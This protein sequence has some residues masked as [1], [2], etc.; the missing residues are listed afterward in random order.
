MRQILTV[1]LSFLLTFSQSGCDGNTHRATGPVEGTLEV[2]YI[3]VGQADSA[4]ILCGGQSMLIDGGNV[5]DSSLLVSYL[6][7]QGISKLGYVVDTHAHEDHVGGLSGPLAKY[8]ADQVYAPVTEYDSKAFRDFTKYAGEVTVPEPG[9]TWTLG[10]AVVTVL[11]PQKEYSETNNTSI[12]LRVDF[13]ETSFLFTGD[14]ERGAEQDMLDA[15]CDLEATVLKVGHHGSDTSTSYPFLREVAPR[16]AVISVGEDNSYGHPSEDVLSRLRDADT[17]L[18]RTDL[19]GTVVAVSDGKSVT[20][21]TER[22][23]DVR[24]N[25]TAAEN[26]PYIGNTNSKVY[27]RPTCGSLPAERSR[28]EFETGDDAQAAGYTPC[29][30]CKP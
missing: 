29:G 26:G 7:G 8:G 6:E 14:A 20:F 9:D 4:L 2:H 23:Q 3:D 22:N 18:Y 10:S 11:G 28:T 1:I 12:V 13:G 5:A 25:P 30:R 27:H 15:G 21:T 17:E 24:T 19:Q 16:Y